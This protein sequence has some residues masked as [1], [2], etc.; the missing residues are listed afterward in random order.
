[1]PFAAVFA[2]CVIPDLPW[3]VWRL[4]NTMG[5][6]FEPIS[7]YAY[8][9]AQASLVGC[10]FACVAFGFL[11]TNFRLVAAFALLG[12]LLHLVLDSLQDKWGNGVH[13]FAPYNWKILSVGIFQIDSVVIY[14]LAFAGIIP[15]L[16]VTKV[17]QDAI[18]LC[19]NPVRLAICCICFIAYFLVPFPYI[20]S[21]VASDSRY[22]QT[23]ENK[24]ERRGK[25][26]EL[27][28]ESVSIV[29]DTWHITT[30]TGEVLAI[31]NP[32]ASMNDGDT[33][34]IRAEFL[35]QRKIWLIDWKRHSGI[36]DMPSYAGLLAIVCWMSAVLILNRRLKSVANEGAT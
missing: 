10:F 35:D 9:I 32:D 34:S 30:H 8:L 1:M 26:L 15:F 24:N 11:F 25:L 23:L 14:L 19:V 2:G 6:S 16:F 22:L 28:R 27:D 3:I 13:L 17:R 18:L 31:M 36:R 12:C 4:V 7:A 5:F 29:E 20:N 33:Y 21:V